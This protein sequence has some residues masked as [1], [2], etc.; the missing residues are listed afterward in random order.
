VNDATQESSNHARATSVRA[1]GRKAT[2]SENVASDRDEG[3]RLRSVMRISRRT[4]YSAF[5][6]N[7]GACSL[8]PGHSLFFGSAAGGMGKLAG[9][10]ACRCPWRLGTGKLRSYLA[11]L[12]HGTRQLSVDKT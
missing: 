12:A 2:S 6:G 5:G 3:D 9:E 7:M 1:A 11:T 4:G 8:V 10:P